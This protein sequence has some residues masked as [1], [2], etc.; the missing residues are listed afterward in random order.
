MFMFVCLCEAVIAS[1]HF[2]NVLPVGALTDCSIPPDSVPPPPRW[3]PLPTPHP[4]DPGWVV[5][6]AMALHP[7]QGVW[8]YTKVVDGGV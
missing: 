2:L 7:Y 6:S 5:P 1:Y 8:V 3:P 4:F